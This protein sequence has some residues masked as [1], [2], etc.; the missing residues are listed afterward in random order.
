MGWHEEG[1]G[2]YSV[3]TSAGPMPRY[4]PA[5]DAAWAEDVFRSQVGESM[6]PD[7]YFVCWSE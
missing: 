4:T 2:A 3:I 6:S 1:K 7:T 5:D